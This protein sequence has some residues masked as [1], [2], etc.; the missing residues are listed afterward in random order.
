MLVSLS[1]TCKHYAVSISSLA[2]V[3]GIEFLLTYQYAFRHALNEITGKDLREL[4]VKVTI[5]QTCSIR[6]YLI[7][8]ENLSFD[9]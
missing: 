3:T 8:G 9:V 5:L 6:D 1:R 4:N 2:R 7:R